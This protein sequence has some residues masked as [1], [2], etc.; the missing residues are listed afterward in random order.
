MLNRLLLHAAGAA[1]LLATVWVWA[2]FFIDIYEAS[3]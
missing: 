2:N 1:A 3:K